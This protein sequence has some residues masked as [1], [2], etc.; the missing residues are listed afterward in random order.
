MLLN[1]DSFIV[2]D[3]FQNPESGYEIH[4]NIKEVL[5]TFF[6]KYVLKKIR[7]LNSYFT[8]QQSE[9][10]EEDFSLMGVKACK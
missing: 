1:I 9:T 2:S 5:V 3:N 8:S 6:Y 10:I 4:C 7:M